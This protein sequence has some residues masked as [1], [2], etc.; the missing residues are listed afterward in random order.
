MW[1]ILFCK[2]RL[3]MTPYRFLNCNWFLYNVWLW[4]WHFDWYSNGSFNWNWNLWINKVQHNS[5][6]IWLRGD[7][8]FATYW[9]VNWHLN[10][11]RWWLL[12]NYWIWSFNLWNVCLVSQKIHLIKVVKKRLTWTG[13]GAGT[14]T[15]YGRSTGTL[16]ATGTFLITSTG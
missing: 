3:Q 16:T 15:G 9:S 8:K 6:E 10:W 1:I 12:N 4:N 13:Y 2:S 5:L 14:C 11:I 7:Q